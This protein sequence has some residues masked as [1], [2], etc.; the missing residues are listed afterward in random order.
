[1][2]VFLAGWY[3]DL[4]NTDISDHPDLDQPILYLQNAFTGKFALC[5]SPHVKTRH[6]WMSENTISDFISISWTTGYLVSCKEHYIL[7]PATLSLNCLFYWHFPG[8]P[9]KSFMQQ[10]LYMSEYTLVH[11]LLC[12]SVVEHC[13][14]CAKGC[15]FDSQGTHVLCLTWM[16]L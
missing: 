13:V 6:I 1:M 12:G 11:V 10:T 16:Q 14:R 9:T 15:G 8:S 7:S 2:Y 5:I 4:Y 3:D